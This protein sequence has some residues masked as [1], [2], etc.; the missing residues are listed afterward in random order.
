MERIARCITAI[1]TAVP[2]IDTTNEYREIDRCFTLLNMFYDKFD[3]DKPVSLADSMSA[4][5]TH[6]QQ[7]QRHVAQTYPTS[8]SQQNGTSLS[9]PS[10]SVEADPHAVTLLL[11]SSHTTDLQTIRVQREMVVAQLFQ[12]VKDVYG[13]RNDAPDTNLLILRHGAKT[14][15]DQRDLSIITLNEA[16][17]V[18]LLQSRVAVRCQRMQRRRHCV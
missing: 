10:R 3:G 15:R 6:I 14:Y 1:R 4:P 18:F 8:S 12:H 11:K 7:Q 17:P 9:H 5:Q 16:H 2:H 13:I